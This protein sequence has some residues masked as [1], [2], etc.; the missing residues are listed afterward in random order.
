MQL[1]KIDIAGLIV[2]GLLMIWQ[3][4]R[5][6]ELLVHVGSKH[7]GGT[8]DF[9]ESNLGVGYVR[10]INKYIDVRGGAYDNSYYR[11]SVYVGGG[12]HL[13]IG[14]SFDV[15]IQGGA[16]SGYAGTAQGSGTISPFVLPY[17]RGRYRR[18]FGEVGYIPAVNGI[19][20]VTFTVGVEL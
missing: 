11:T 19:S 2:V 8:T 1:T 4:A 9:N 12:A 13:P 14:N 6:D 16:V 5:S 7:S 15:G 18:V 17:V 3:D 20:V 10:N